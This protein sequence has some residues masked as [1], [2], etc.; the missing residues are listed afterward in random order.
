MVEHMIV[1][2]MESERYDP[3]RDRDVVRFMGI[4]PRGTFHVELPVYGPASLRTMRNAFK[5]R[6]IGLLE[7]GQAPREVVL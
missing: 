6:V 4:T 1:R 5:E 3:M 2:F 7:E